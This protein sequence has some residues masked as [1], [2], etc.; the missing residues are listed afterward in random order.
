MQVL[1][2]NLLKKLVGYVG[3]HKALKLGWKYLIYPKLKVWTESNS[4]PEWDEKILAWV[5]VNINK[6]IDML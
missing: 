1:L 5:D 4:Y 3:F 2:V 6:A